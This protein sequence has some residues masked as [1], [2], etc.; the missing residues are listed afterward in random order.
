[1]KFIV[2]SY[3]YGLH[4]IVLKKRFFFLMIYDNNIFFVLYLV[5]GRLHDKINIT[6]YYTT[7]HRKKIQE[8]KLPVN[9][10]QTP[11]FLCIKKQFLF[12]IK[13]NSSLSPQTTDLNRNDFSRIHL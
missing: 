7:F 10:N 5:E 8:Q 3:N 2:G 11:S 4:C 1:M 9:A 6:I 13:I 12:I